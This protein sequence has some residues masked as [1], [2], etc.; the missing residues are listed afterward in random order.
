MRIVTA[1]FNSAKQGPLAE[2][3]VRERERKASTVARY[4]KNALKKNMVLST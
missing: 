3:H 4:E 1:N 2:L